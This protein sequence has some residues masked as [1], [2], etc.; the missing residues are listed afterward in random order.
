MKLGTHDLDRD[1]VVVAEIGNN[2]EGDRRL[3][4]ELIEAA[5]EAGADAVKVQVIDPERLVHCSQSERIAQLSRYRLSMDTL[6]EMAALAERKGALFIASA[7]DLASLDAISES[8]AAIKIASGDL[9]F[10]PLL[11]RAAELEKPILLSTGMATLEEVRTAVDV[12]A[13]HGNGRPLADRLA[14]LHCVSLYPTPLHEAN[15]SAITT[16]A[17]TFGV[18]VG[19]SDHTLG[20]EAAVIAL[21]QGAR[22]I[23]K[24]FTLDKTRSSYRD[25]ALSAD[26]ADM[27]RLVTVAHEYERILGSGVKAPSAAE[28]TAATAARRSVVAARD[29][30]AG[31]QLSEA[32][33][34]YVRPRDGSPPAAAAQMVGRRLRVPLKRHELLRDH[35]LDP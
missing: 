4:L 22:I 12:V 7:F 30:P 16:L 13:A 3:A 18:T 14:V 5:A 11:A 6:L 29:L 34:E 24:H 21:T 33:L 35:Q 23:E 31:T 32:D 17:R 26:P 9:D 19:Y 1:V 10:L 25:H 28:R 15:L 8:V 2:H 27:K 20:T